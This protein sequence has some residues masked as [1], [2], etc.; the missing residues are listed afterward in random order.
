MM[1]I[2]NAVLAG[3]FSLKA[4]RSMRGRIKNEKIQNIFEVILSPVGLAK[5]LFGREGKAEGDFPVSLAIAAIIKDEAPYIR[6]WIE[7]HKLMG[8]GEFYLYDNESS[9]EIADVL[10]PYISEGVV[11]YEK[12]R[13]KKRQCDAYND[14]IEKYSARAK[15]IAFLD[16]DEFLM[17]AEE[18]GRLIDVA[19]SIMAQDKCI[20][21]CTVNWL[22]YGSGGHEKKPEGLVTE[23]Y[24]MRGKDDFEANA[25]YKSIVNPRR[26]FAFICPH[27]PTYKRG[28]YAVNERG[29]RVDTST[30]RGT[31]EKLRINHYFTK[32]KEEYEKKMLRGMA[33]RSSYRTMDDFYRHDVNDVEDGT[34]LRYAEAV[35]RACL[36]E[37]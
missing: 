5:Y 15:Y 17:P 25:N 33:D 8:V 20:G 26:A 10:A 36:S 24:V 32:S 9:D 19:D 37:N 35:K 30:F 16:V 22:C 34:A 23:A 18:G 3:A 13:G 1:N 4:V 12:I 2:K 14:A 7:F 28:Y 6:E 29:V 31:Y 21:G 27:Y 11:R